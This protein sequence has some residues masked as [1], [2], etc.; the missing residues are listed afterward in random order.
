MRESHEEGFSPQMITTDG[1]I[2]DEWDEWKARLQF[3]QYVWEDW[4][5]DKTKVAEFIEFLGLIFSY[6]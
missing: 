6:S 1:E 2:H 4:W 5:P 3:A